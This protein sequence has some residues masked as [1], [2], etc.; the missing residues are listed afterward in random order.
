MPQWF[1][2]TVAMAAAC[3]IVLGVVIIRDRRNAAHGNPDETPDVIE[4]MTMMVGVLYAIV[5]GL[6]IAGVWEA[7]NAAHDAIN[8][9][10]QAL[11]E[12]RE[13]VAVWPAP[14]QDRIRGD[15][16]R[17]V[18]YVSAREWPYMVRTGEL[19]SS[20]TTLLDAMRHD[21]SGYTPANDHE[22][23]AYQPLVD[24]V[25]AVDAARSAR[26]EAAAPTLP[27]ALR[28]THHRV[29]RD[30]SLRMSVPS[31]PPSAGTELSQERVK[32]TFRISFGRSG[33]VHS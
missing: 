27:A 10:A 17:Y 16:D 13:R 9:E 24:Q 14:V 19:T 26:E 15:V 6:A 8:Q 29:C 11:H 20:G 23:Q 21:V 28:R 25:A 33:R 5:L 7:R 30:R 22:T 18:Q 31:G 1:V 12:V 4:Y 2:F 3:L 32:I